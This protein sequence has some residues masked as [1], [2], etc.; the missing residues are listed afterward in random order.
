[1][2]TYNINVYILRTLHYLQEMNGGANALDALRG[3][4]PNVT[5]PHIPPEDVP[6]GQG[7]RTTATCKKWDVRD[8]FYSSRCQSLKEGHVILTL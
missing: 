4:F 2:H 8:V 1:M 7:I 5:L 3:A 6:N